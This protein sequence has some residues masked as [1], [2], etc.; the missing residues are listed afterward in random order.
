MPSYLGVSRAVLDNVIFCHQEESLWPL[1]QPADLKKR[2]DEIFEA[3]KYTKAIENIKVLAK[4]QRTLLIEHKKD[5]E[6]TKIIKDKGQKIKKQASDLDAECDELRKQHTDYEDRIKQAARN[7]EAAWQKAETAGLIVGDLRGKRIE[8]QTKEESVQS[9]RQNLTEME[10]SD[11]DLQ[12]MVEQYE[13]RVQ[14]YR[15]ELDARKAK[16]RSLLDEIEQARARVSAKERECGTYEAEA[17]RYDQQLENRQKLVKETARSHGIRGFDVE[18]DDTKVRAFIDR[19]SKMARD[20]NAAFERARR[21]TQE[22]LQGAQKDLSEINQ[23]KSVLTSQKENHRRSIQENDRKIGNLQRELNNIDVDESTK[24][25]LESTIRDVETRLATAKSDMENANWDAQAQAAAGEV[26][27]LNNRHKKLSNELVESTN[28]T[29]EADRLEDAQKNLKDSERRLETLVGV[30]GDRIAS[31][32][33]QGWNVQSLQSDFDQKKDEHDTLLTDAKKQRDGVGYEKDILERELRACRKDLTDKRESESR[34]A[35]AIRSAL[36]CEPD[37]Y[38]EALQDRERERDEAVAA[39]ESSQAVIMYFKACIKAAKAPKPCCRMCTRAFKDDSE[40][41]KMMKN[42]EREMEKQKAEIK[43]WQ[44]YVDEAEAKLEQAKAVHKDFND[45]EKLRS[46]IPDVTKKEKELTSKVLKLDEQ[47]ERKYELVKERETAKRDVDDLSGNVQ[48]ITNFG[49]EIDELKTRI[50]ELTSK[51]K[52]GEF[53]RSIQQIQDDLQQVMEEIAAANLRAQTAYSGRDKALALIHK[54][55]G[56]IRDKK[57]DLS[58]TESALKEKRSLEG[59]VDDLK[60]SN[61]EQWD[62]SK[63]A[64][65]EIRELQPQLEMAEA[66]YEDI[67]CRGAEKDRELQADVNKVSNSVSQ[68]RVANQEI[69][70]YEAKGGKDQVERG[71]IEVE[72]GKKE[73]A[74][75]EAEQRQVV[76]EV[77]ALEDKL[78]DHA[79]T[80]RSISDNQRYRRDLRQLQKVREEI[81]ELET[82]NAEEDKARYEA[83]GSK[84]QMQRNKLAAEQATVIGSLKSKDETLKQLVQDWETDYKDAARKY[85]E[86]HVKVEATKACVE[87]L[88]RY[89]GALDQAI[90]KYHSLKMEEINRIID[91]LWRNTYQGTDVDTILIK[92]EHETVKANKTYNYRVCMMKQDAEMDMRGRCSAG[93]KVLASI[94]IRLAL[95]ECFGTN[96]GLI[97]LDEPTTNLDRENIRALAESL[98]GII[99]HRKAQK[100]F[101][102]IVITHD[103]EFLRLMGANDFADVYYRVERNANQKSIITRQ[104]ISEMV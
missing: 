23:K 61:S 30:Y 57:W 95:A 81:A 101:Q 33:G 20:Q 67:A 2:F 5:E 85:K 26:E 98:A 36:D 66:K 77:K 104:P 82:H 49:K 83:E 41:E 51:Q 65:T 87:D 52:A 8:Q 11:E 10:D 28:N 40:T 90:M 94:I 100:N 50:E 12:R 38:L 54:L 45:W 84:W 91:E 7:A 102:L 63:A 99:K 29:R 22:A 73:V 97:A 70:A 1:A 92:S 62:A 64:D 93:Q 68:L 56:D 15:T 34:A 80:K 103:E 32:V 14:E 79:E 4:Q 96:C 24:V 39:T 55:E 48:K 13:E 27:K 3:Q 78:R 72:D 42:V 43:D 37:E 88:G 6:Y 46:E 69:E 31:V 25:A 16:Y 60:K 35:A 86:A 19:I 75:K 53:S 21:E 74:R 17:A 18:L 76:C 71:R 47:L 9:L 89:G 59:Q 44:A 58:K